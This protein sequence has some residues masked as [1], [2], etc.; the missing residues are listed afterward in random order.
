MKRKTEENNG[1]ECNNERVDISCQCIEYV[2]ELV[3][4]ARDIEKLREA[5]PL[6]SLLV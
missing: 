2:D 1:I 3:N 6:N 4:R 5:F